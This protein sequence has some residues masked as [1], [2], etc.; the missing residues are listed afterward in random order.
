MGPETHL[1]SKVII[2]AC[3]NYQWYKDY[4]LMNRVSDEVRNATREKYQELF[5]DLKQQKAVV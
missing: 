4:P 1:N 5:E 3:K 2:N